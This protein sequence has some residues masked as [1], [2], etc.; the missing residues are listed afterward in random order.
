MVMYRRLGIAS[1]REQFPGSAGKKDILAPSS[2]RKK[3][4][5]APSLRKKDILAPSLRKCLIPL[6]NQNS[7]SS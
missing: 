3:D 4:I 7:S 6:E 1:Q 2:F 5:L